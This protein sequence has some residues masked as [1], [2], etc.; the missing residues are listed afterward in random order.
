VNGLLFDS[1][2]VAKAAGSV[3]RSGSFERSKSPKT[4]PT[5]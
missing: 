5:L 1:T 3:M 2:Q 4:A